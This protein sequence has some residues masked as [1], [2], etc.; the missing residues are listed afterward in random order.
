MFAPQIIFDSEVSNY[1][2]ALRVPSGY[3][4]HHNKTVCEMYFGMFFLLQILSLF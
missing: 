3:F 1:I 2:Q 4:G